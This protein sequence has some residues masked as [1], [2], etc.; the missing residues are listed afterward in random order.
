MKSH[1][2]KVNKGVGRAEFRP[3]QNMLL[4]GDGSGGE[5]CLTISY[6]DSR[7]LELLLAEPGQIR[8][9]DEILRYAWEDRIVSAGSLNQCIFNLRNL[10]GDEKLHEIIQTV[11]RRGYRWNPDFVL[12]AT[13][14]HLGPAQ[15][16]RPT[17]VPFSLPLA[18]I[19]ARA[20]SMHIWGWN[21]LL[22]A[23]LLTGWVLL[24]YDYANH[25]PDLLAG[26]IEFEAREH[27]GYRLNVLRTSYPVDELLAAVVTPAPP[28][29]PGHYWIVPRSNDFSVSCVRAD[30]TALNAI[31][32]KG[33]GLAAAVAAVFQRCSA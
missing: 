22:G 8:S 2:L 10:I 1:H 9:R 12:D 4:I 26:P 17:P 28:E 18:A 15:A 13:L 11:P 5:E 3:E 20:S 27:L 30:A 21:A 25:T 23:L 19:E 6:T 29:K 7:A 32:P 24:Q 31:V 16:P 14:D 33:K